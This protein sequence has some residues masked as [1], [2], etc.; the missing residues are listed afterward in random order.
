[1]MEVFMGLDPDIVRGQFPALQREV[2]SQ[3]AIYADG[4]SGTQVSQRVIDA[5][6]GYMTNGSS[7]Q[8]GAYV[9]GRETHAMAHAALE[10][11]ADLLNARQSAEIVVGQNMTSLTYAMSRSISREW[12][13]GDEIIVTR[14][15]HEGN[16]SPWLQAAADCD[17]TVRW[18]DVDTSDCTLKLDDLP[19]LLNT[20]TR[21][22][23]ITYASNAVGS[24]TD[25]EEVSNIVR[26]SDTLVYVDA[27]HYTPHGIIDVQAV[28]CDFLAC[29]TY[30]FFGPHTGVLYGK[31]EHLD[32]LDCYQV[33]P[34]S[35][36]PP[37]KW[38]TGTQSFESLAG[39]IATLDYLA[40]LSGLSEDDK[41]R[42]RIVESLRQTRTYEQSLSRHFLTGAATVPE[43]RIYG[44]TD[45]ERLEQR[46]PTFSIELEGYGPGELAERLGDMGIFVSNGNYYA[47]ELMESLDANT[48]GGLVRIGFVHYNTLD[49]LDRILNALKELA[50]AK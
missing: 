32:R 35:K 44:I 9:T 1:M 2:N 3:P 23:A 33:R 49:E 6:A 36:Q 26:S 20:R 38:E 45:I 34:A 50:E 46:A 17:V 37:R 11:L 27:V 7:N 4:P 48:S 29:S 30:K 24:I 12:Q 43:L 31:Y 39:I 8:G 28:D 21:L 13:P 42:D 19:G 15:D 5:M 25:M 18:L 41:R 16:V 14:L 22:L 10:A 47:Y 40:E